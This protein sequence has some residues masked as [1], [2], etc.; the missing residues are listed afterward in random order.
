VVCNRQSATDN[1]FLSSLEQD[2]TRH[3]KEKT[4]VTISL[5]SSLQ[6]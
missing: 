2:I 1:A 5:V 4:A 6:L 3:I